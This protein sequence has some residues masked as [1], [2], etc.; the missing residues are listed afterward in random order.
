MGLSMALVLN[1]MGLSFVFISD[2]KIMELVWPK[3][4]TG[5]SFAL[6]AHGMGSGLVLVLL[7]LWL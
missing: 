2:G 3:I 6:V 5:H 4:V 1:G 7:V